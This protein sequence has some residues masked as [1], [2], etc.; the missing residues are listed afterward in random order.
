VNRLDNN[1]KTP[2]S[3]EPIPL[4]Q[5]ACDVLQAWKKESPPKNEYVF[6]S[7]VGPNKPIPEPSLVEE[8]QQV[9]IKSG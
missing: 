5:Y 6:P 2:G 4:S 8:N 3:A 7:P 9:L 1:V